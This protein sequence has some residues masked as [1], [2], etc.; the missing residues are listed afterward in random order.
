MHFTFYSRTG[1]AALT[2][3]SALVTYA[4]VELGTN[5]PIVILSITVTYLKDHTSLGIG[6]VFIIMEVSR[7]L[8]EHSDELVRPV[9]SCLQAPD[10]CS[11]CL[12]KSRKPCFSR[13]LK[14]GS[15][16]SWSN[17]ELIES[18][19]DRISNSAEAE[20]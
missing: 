10:L 2:K 19:V 8:A 7:Y 16:P 5:I 13:Q 6:P 11:S 12:V 20:L 3:V 18:R 1:M 15:S 9:A 14:R 4:L 17:F